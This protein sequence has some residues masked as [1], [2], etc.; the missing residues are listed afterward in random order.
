MDFNVIV[1][2]PRHPVLSE[3]APSVSAPGTPARDAA[4]TELNAVMTD[5]AHPVHSAWA[6][7]NMAVV[8]QHLKPFYEKAVAESPPGPLARE[9]ASVSTD[10]S[11]DAEAQA[12]IETALRAELGDT[13]DTTM[14][15]MASGAKFLFDGEE[16]Q[17]ALTVLADRM[18]G[19]GPKAEALG[20]KF[21]ADLAKLQKQGG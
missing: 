15:A 13:Y 5:P 4:R 12:E 18:T 10:F 2:E 21:L 9:S 1:G 6:R 3:S 19:L 17:H 8:D 20:V 11:G 16:G 7:G 14:S